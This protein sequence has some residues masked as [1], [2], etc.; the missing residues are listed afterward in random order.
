MPVDASL[1]TQ[2]LSRNP[3]KFLV[4]FSSTRAVALREFRSSYCISRFSI[5]QFRNEKTL[6]FLE[7]TISN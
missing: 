4:K 7:R 2:Q 1:E 6:L 5:R 3:D